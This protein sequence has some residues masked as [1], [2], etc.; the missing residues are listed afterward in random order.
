MTTTHTTTPS[1]TG[2][3]P[4]D[5]LSWVRPA[6]RR[7]RA[8]HVGGVPDVTVKLNQNESPFD[9]PEEVKREV[10]EALQRIAFN[11]YPTEQPD[12]LREALAAYAGHD[13]EGVLVGNGSNELTYTL[14]LALLDPGTPVVLPRPMF[15][16]YESMVRLYDGALTSVPPRPDLSFDVEALVSAVRRTSPALTVVTT[17]NNPTGL[18]LPLEEV[19]RIVHAAPGIVVVDEA[20]VEFSREESARV[21]LGQYPNLLVMRTLS[22]AFGLA[23]LRIGYLMGHPALIRELLKARVPFM[24]DRVAET[25]AL[26]L[27]S[28]PELL[29]ERRRAILEEV[30][31]LTTALAALEGVSVIPSQTNFVLFKTPLEPAQLMARLAHDG[32]L[33]R[34]MGGYPELQGYLRVNAGTGRENQA[35]LDALKSALR[36]HRETP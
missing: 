16:L 4:A 20:Y 26:A 28:R 9:V 35:F 29:E 25:V 21:L 24:V 17:P 27:L 31:R 1:S 22:K 7:E 33:V 19:E 14:G 18:A 34:S 13:P 36:Q 2:R 5:V 30:G 10:V 6:V 23:G 3:E 12:R 8:Y 15:A 32:V 11:R